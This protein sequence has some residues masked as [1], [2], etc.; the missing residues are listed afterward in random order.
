M[1]EGHCESFHLLLISIAQNNRLFC[2]IPTA[3]I[4]N[5]NIVELQRRFYYI[6]VFFALSIIHGG[7]A[8]MFMSSV[9][10]DY[11]QNHSV[12]VD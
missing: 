5:H 3:H 11:Y 12:V 4:L 6:G 8:P 9:V 2:G 7:P 10:V 1:Q